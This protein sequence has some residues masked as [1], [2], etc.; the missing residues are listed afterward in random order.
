MAGVDSGYPETR[1]DD[2]GASAPTRRPTAASVSAFSSTGPNGD[3]GPHGADQSTGPGS[4]RARLFTIHR[5]RPRT[6]LSALLRCT[7]ASRR[8]SATSA[9]D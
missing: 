1:G 2:T 8:R 6:R 3:R 4:E 9:Q 7:L 5:V